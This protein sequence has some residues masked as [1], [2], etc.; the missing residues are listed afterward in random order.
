[1]KKYFYKQGGKF[2]SAVFILLFTSVFSQTQTIHF[3]DAGN[4][5]GL[6]VIRQDAS[7][8]E[9]NFNIDKYYI[10]KLNVSGETMEKIG[11]EGVLLPNTEGAPDLP[12]YSRYI[13]VPQG[14]GVKV[15]VKTLKSEKVTGKNIA[16]APRIPKETDKG[17]LLRKKDM[18][19]YAKNAFYP[20]KNVMVSAKR[21][22][23]GVDVVLVSISPFRYNP[24][25][26]VLEINRDMDISV[27]FEGGNGQFGEKR[28]RSRYWDPILKDNILN[29]ALLP[30][31]DYNRPPSRS[32]NGWE[33]VIISPDDAGFL[34]WADSIRLFRIKQGI[35]THVVTTTEI[36]GNTTNAIEHYVDSAY[37][38]WS[39]PPAAML[40]LGDYGTSGNTVVSPVYNNYCISDNIYADVDGDNLPDVVFA[41]ITAQNTDQ[42]EH[43]VTKFLNYER[44]P[45]T[46]PDFYDHPITAMGWQ[47]ERWFQ[48]CSEI[49]AGFFENSL[50]K[51][52]V[53]EN[54][55][56]S[57]NPGGG[58]WST[59]S[60]TSTIVDYFGENGLGY[61]PDS[62]NYLNDWGGNATRINNDI[63]SGAFLLQHRD[64][65]SETGW[66][67]PS[68]G[69]SD[70][71]GLYNT[72]LTWIFSI[73]CLTGKFN[74]NGECFAEKFHRYTHNGQNSGALGITAATEVS[75]S[76]V[77]DTYVWGMYDN[78][79]PDFMP[80]YGTTP[81]SRGIVPAFGNAA[82]KY[83]LEQ[84]SWPSNPN[85]K[86]VTYYLFHA[87][88][89][90][91][92]RLYSEVPQNL[93][94]VHDPVLL[95]G[96]DYFTVEADE[97]AFIC[98]TVGDEIIGT[99]D[100]TGEPV[101]VSIIPQQPGT[102]VDVVIT[103]QNYYR[104]QSRVEVIPPD[105]PYCM[106]DSHS[107][108][109]TLGNGN[110]IPEFDE[111]IL[112]SMTMKNLGNEDGKNVIVNLHVNDQ[113]INFIDSTE[114]Y[115][116]IHVGEHKLRELAY[117]FHVSNGIPDQHK[118]LFNVHATD[119]NDSSWYS[120]FY[121]TFNAPL[122]SPGQMIIDDSQYGNGN[123]MLDPGEQ[124][125]MKIKTS[126]KGHC[127]IHNVIVNLIPYNAYVTVTSGPD[128][129]PLLS[130]FGG[131]WSEFNVT[132][133]ND[134]PTGVFAEMHY[135]A[136][137][138]GY[139][140]PKTYYPKIGELIEDWETGDFTKFDWVLGGNEPWF[141]TNQFPYEGY[142]H[143]KSGV[144]QN[145]QTSELSLSYKVMTQDTIRFYK[146]V[147]SE[148]G[149][150]KLLFYI[151]NQEL[152]NWSGTSVGWTHEKFPV[153]PGMH[154]FKWVYQKD[155][156]GSSGADC[157]WLDYIQLPTELVTTLFAGPDDEVCAGQDYQCSGTA[158]NFDSVY[159]TTTGDGVFNP[160]NSFTPLYT[161]GP[162]DLQNGSVIL[163]ENIVDVEGL[164]FSDSLTL[165][166]LY[167]PGAP[168]TPSGPDYV[169]LY[170]ITETSYAVIPV[171]DATGYAWVIYPAQAGSITSYD[172][173]A[174]VT[175]NPDYLGEAYLKVQAL[176]NC[177]GGDFS[178]S[179]YIFVDNTVGINPSPANRKLHILP[180]PNKG[181]FTVNL[182]TGNDK[183]VSFKLMSSIG[184][185][186]VAKKLTP[187]NGVINYRADQSTLPNGIYFVVVEQ[188][189]NRYTRKILINK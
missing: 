100:A 120:K 70:I 150:D 19:I 62:P 55:I 185:E 148:D 180:N 29:S 124:A 20:E 136:T 87:H 18:R 140:V 163:I 166:F 111:N 98:L 67:E 39:I 145:S 184:K 160:S 86:E 84:S 99:A 91:F 93:T 161:A 117:K 186:I 169:D 125:V 139:E 64:H 23:R 96:L 88:G 30:E 121:M 32:D 12:V 112:V 188:G 1:M 69:N 5:H 35:T 80:D 108:N 44:N 97:G 3:K 47:T 110:N 126:N 31:I 51:N 171:E 45:P 187:V 15:N 43:M 89:G 104:Y 65:G 133:S 63:N 36:G 176:N 175:W 183:K 130:F 107:I 181:I 165:S 57:G 114:N 144:I 61:I 8:I 77:N 82:G 128:T 27:T 72:D 79:W 103:K 9:M 137:A 2:L 81:G 146:K 28:L 149:F 92:T 85:N 37:N 42:L 189:K 41:R 141:I 155:Y 132:V 24:V 40:I 109:D 177:G 34:A 78:M 162:Q 58:V 76:F 178:D 66:G 48:L 21:K 33:Y 168:A 94:V 143:A 154:T 164:T 115:D 159:W 172:T 173:T 127:I 118:V 135:I 60:N 83:F 152:G 56:Y 14:A 105:G 16:P 147:S 10:D 131:S 11:I 38:N 170:K 49:I 134:A 116:T 129:I 26:G 101:D 17:P 102:F 53:R 46:N 71:D 50:G 74:Y 6:T 22:I 13:A 142:Y 157:A 122:I 158:T 174:I 68:Y 75:Y 4:K 113:Y 90:A 52:V 25:T 54:A 156:S 182:K 179:L 123:G 153:S 59:A 119:E 151:D 138:A 106:H 167:P 73:N 95:S 7:G